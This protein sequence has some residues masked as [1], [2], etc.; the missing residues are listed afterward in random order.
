MN[1]ILEKLRKSGLRATPQRIAIYEALESFGHAK[2]EAV[3]EKVRK[4]FE[5]ISI[6]TVYSSLNT[7]AEKGVISRLILSD[8]SQYFD[9]TNIPHSHFVCRECGTVF[10]VEDRICPSGIEAKKIGKIDFYN[11][12]YYGV[13]NRCKQKNRR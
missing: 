6:A 12:V 10:D 1:V 9:I 5:G 8:N 11:L 2:P 13:C 4:K 7:L 3:F